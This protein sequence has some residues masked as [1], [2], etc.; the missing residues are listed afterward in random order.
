MFISECMKQYL[1]DISYCP[2]GEKCVDSLGLLVS[3]TD[4]K[5]CSFVDDIKYLANIADNVDMVFV[6][7]E[8]VGKLNSDMG[9]LIVGRPR[10]TFFHLHNMLKGDDRYIRNAYDTEIDATAQISD[11]SVIPRKNVRIGKNVIIEPFVTI[12][13]NTIIEDDCIIRSG[14]R[15]GSS[16]FEHKR[17]ND[18]IFSVE[19]LGGTILKHDVEIQNNTCIDRAIYPWDDT[20][21]GAYT[22]VDNLVHVGHAAKIG[23]C[24]MIVAQVGIGGRTVVGNHVWLGFGATIRNGLIIEDMARVNMGSIVTQNVLAGESVTGNFAIPHERFMENLK[25]SV[26]K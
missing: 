4:R 7:E 21:I 3:N 16:G 8:L 13:E 17:E 23:R 24:C 6:T 2:V 12:Y 22:K 5:L 9:Y 26:K 1:P 19:H 15:I 11:L 10:E 14:A 20:I 25:N 18:H